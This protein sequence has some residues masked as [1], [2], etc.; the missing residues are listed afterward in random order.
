MIDFVFKT[1]S[2]KALHAILLLT[3]I[4]FIGFFI[5]VQGTS[6]LPAE[7]FTETDAYLYYWQAQII[8]ENGK[9][10][11]RDMHRWLP[12]GRDNEQLLSLYAYA[13]AYIQKVITSVF[14]NITI[15]Q[16]ILYAPPVCFS[17]GLLAFSFFLYRTYGGLFAIINTTLLA[18]LPG[19]VERSTAGFGDRDAWCWML[20]ILSVISYLWKEQHSQRYPR[21]IGTLLS[22]FF[23]FLGSLS[24]EGFGIFVVIILSA[25]LWKFCTTDSDD[26]LKEYLI[27]ILMFVPWLYIIS[28]AYR[29]GYGFSTHLNALV[30]G[31][32][33][34]VLGIRIGHHFLLTKAPFAEKLRDHGRKLAWTF[35][36]GGGLAGMCYILLQSNTFALTAY[37]LHENEI[38]KTVSELDDPSLSFWKYR[39]GAVFILGSLGLAIRSLWLWKWDGVLLSIALLLFTGTT[40]FSQAISRWVGTDGGNILF[41]TGFI[42]VPVGLGITT[43]H[44]KTPQAI[45]TL[46]VIVW[47]L[48]WIGLARFGKR[49]D[50]FISVPLAFGTA[51]FLTILSTFLVEKLKKNKRVSLQYIRQ[52]IPACITVVVLVPTL[53]WAPLGG[54]LKQAVITAMQMRQ[55]TPGTGEI[56]EAFKWMKAS[57]PQSSVVA[58][59]WT[60][61]SQLNVLAGVK[62]IRDQDH[63][64][65]HWLTLYNQHV[66]HAKNELEV[67]E[68]LKSH[69]ATHLMLTGEEPSKSILRGHL[70]NAFILIFMNNG[71]KIWQVH[72]PSHIK[73]H[74]KYLATTPEQT[75]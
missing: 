28:P 72:Y 50:F 44:K 11:P 18:T 54:H 60:Y 66:Y 42:L 30:I 61:G 75:P 14:P 58:A 39:Y 57:L 74:P 73:P 19:S 23:L 40:F 26:S 46:I 35:T 45:A 7:Q 37:P 65:L 68:F 29:S 49:F 22:G 55:P 27:W 43:L 13:I 8:S 32:S 59:N 16:I 38:M 70:S 51:S 12:L 2:S 6:N 67:L 34:T 5:R 53:F 21:L 24:W 20:G 36:L 9:L 15:Y 4:V 63:Y 41:F 64:I 52:H 31:S 1:L 71:V 47:A 25:E 69:N 48:L 17:L 3:G 33:I 56:A 10:P 62:T